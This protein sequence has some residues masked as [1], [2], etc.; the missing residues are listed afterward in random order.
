VFNFSESISKSFQANDLG[1]AHFASKPDARRISATPTPCTGSLVNIDCNSLVAILSSE[2]EATERLV[3]SARQRTASQ[4]AKR[5]EAIERTARIDRILLF[6]QHGDVA[7]EM[8]ERDVT[9]CKSLEDR[10]RVRGQS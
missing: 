10:L 8:S 7:P 4:R 2:S 1:D 5:H 6:F 9:L 3:N